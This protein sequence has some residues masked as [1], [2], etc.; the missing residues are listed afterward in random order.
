MDDK[1]NRVIVSTVKSVRPDAE[2]RL[3]GSRAR[4]NAR[5]DSD[6]DVIVIVNDDH[7][8]TALF[9][10]IGNPLYDYADE[11]NVE[12]NPIL[13]TRKQWEN[14]HPSLFGHNVEKESIVL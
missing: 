3:F 13:Y 4:G 14:R 11:H 6:W 8:S 10:A 2:V 5:K 1:V 9:S 7:I 12:I